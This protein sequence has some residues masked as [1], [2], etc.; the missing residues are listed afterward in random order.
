VLL[1]NG[2]QARNVFWQVGSAARIEVGS[3]MVGTIIAP[4]GVTV[5][6]AGQ[7]IQTTLIGRAI[8]LTASVTLVNTTIVAP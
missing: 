4:A 3:T 6:T 2:A 8:G 7:A 1:L 5:S